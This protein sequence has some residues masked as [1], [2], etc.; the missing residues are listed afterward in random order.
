[1]ATEQ[2][3]VNRVRDF[4]LGDIL[5]SGAVC[6]EECIEAPRF[7]YPD[8]QIIAI[9]DGDLRVLACGSVL[10]TRETPALEPHHGIV[11]SDIST[12]GCPVVF[13]PCAFKKGD[14]VMVYPQGIEPSVVVPEG[15]REWAKGYERYHTLHNETALMLRDWILS[16]KV[17]E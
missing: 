17:K 9:D 12:A 6:V 2:R 13:L 1:M 16:L 10:V 8:L 11:E 14:K 15:I 4:R 7:K 3:E 5:P